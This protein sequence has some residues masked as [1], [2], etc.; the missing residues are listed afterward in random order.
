MYFSL[1]LQRMEDAVK[2]CIQEDARKQYHYHGKIFPLIDFRKSVE[3]YDL[4]PFVC[5]IT[6]EVIGISPHALIMCDRLF[7]AVLQ[8]DRSA[9]SA[10]MNSIDGDN[11]SLVEIHDW[12]FVKLVR[13]IFCNQE[14][15]IS[16]EDWFEML[17]QNNVNFPQTKA[18][19][20]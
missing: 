12:L 18:G 19:E 4:R 11:G 2:V 7:H 6:K 1:L 9:I 8:Y 16:I 14:L 5:R 15:C 20:L 13:R 10:C 3:E 17:K